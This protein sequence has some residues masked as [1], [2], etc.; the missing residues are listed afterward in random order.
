[1]QLN[2]AAFDAFLS[3]IGQDFTWSKAYVCPC[4]SPNSG[5]ASPQCQVCFGRGRY[6]P[7]G[8]AAVAGVSSQKVQQAWQQFGLYQTGDTVLSVPQISPM[9]DAGQFDRLL[10]LNATEQFSINLLAGTNDRLL[11]PV[12]TITRVFW[13]N[14]GL[15]ATI[16][17]AIPTVTAGA[18]TWPN[19]GGPPT[20]TTYSVSGTQ[21]QEFFV[22]GD[23][24]VNRAEHHGLRLPKRIVLRRFDLFGR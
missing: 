16:E 10:A 9:Y 23:Y 3:N 5:A 14:A 12:L 22:W 17:G 18:L 2:P 19:G 15:T 4:I 11:M 21:T 6:W 20:G 24:P 1:M 13:L 8:T 7:T